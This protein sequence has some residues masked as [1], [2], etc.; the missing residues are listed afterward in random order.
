LLLVYQSFS[1]LE[2]GCTVAVNK[3]CQKSEIAPK[4]RAYQLSSPFLGFIMSIQRHVLIAAGTSVF[5][6]SLITNSQVR[7]QYRL[8]S[9]SKL[10][11]LPLQTSPIDPLKPGSFSK[12]ASKLVE[13][14]ALQVLYEFK[15]K[16]G[17]RR[18]EARLLQAKDGSFYGTT[19][20]G[21][22]SRLC[23]T[24]G[25]GT[26]F[27]LTSAGTLKI[28]VSFNVV[29]GALPNASLI[30]GRDGNFYG[31]TSYGGSGDCILN[32]RRGCGT[33][34]QL[35]PRGALTTL[36][37]FD[38]TNGAYP[39]A[40]LVQG[41]DGSFYGTTRAGGSN[42][43]G[44]IFK[45]TRT[46]VLTT[47]V[48]FDGKNGSDPAAS[49]IQAKDGYFYGTT[50]KGG[51][52]NFG[53]IFR[54]TS[55]GDLKTLASFNGRNGENPQAEL[56][57]GID[58]NF[59]GTTL[60]GGVGDFGT[61]FKVTPTGTLVTLVKFSGGNG[62]RPEAGLIQA[63]DGNFY[64]LTKTGGSSSCP[65]GCG[66]AFRVTPKGVLTTLINFSLF[67]TAPT[68]VNPTASLIQGKDGGFYG[69]T[70]GS[71]NSTSGTVFKITVN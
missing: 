49:L 34:L 26:V 57:Q 7:A 10:R 16:P 47:L 36:V 52:R 53:T 62:S 67:G 4:K 68:A 48:D 23:S 30:Q 12:L 22:S 64:G 15:G 71:V 70:E 38:R 24:L 65:A 28:L 20:F 39:Y 43:D 37:E 45:L 60:K 14:I 55:A 17:G 2:N 63:K 33:V 9:L 35:T 21:G 31:T 6:C 25:C 3:Y 11:S 19:Y 13:N 61:V 42:G 50:T 41:R 29:N 5:L 40:G 69:V 27:Q 54:I 32:E 18:P 66:T 8:S 1:S 46:G 59:Y 44:T 56:I 58:G 51:A